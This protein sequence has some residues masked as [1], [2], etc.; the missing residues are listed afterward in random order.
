M[1][2]HSA[3]IQNA[4]AE[5]ERTDA[6]SA[7]RKVIETGSKAVIRRKRGVKKMFDEFFQKGVES[8]VW[9]AKGLYSFNFEILLN[10]YQSSNFFFLF[11]LDVLVWVSDPYYH[12]SKSIPAW[13]SAYVE[14]IGRPT[15]SDEE[16]VS[17]STL[18]RVANDTVRICAR[19][20]RLKGG[21]QSRNQIL[22][23]SHPC[24]VKNKSSGNQTRGE[25]RKY[26][27]DDVL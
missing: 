22:I 19:E 6:E 15:N 23:F 27:D 14:Y 13:L 10:F 12:P 18:R 2:N 7:L 16:F 26:L 5:V 21:N 17:S 11:F 9:E 1:P 20:L 24:L 4:S 3:H 8:Y 25:L